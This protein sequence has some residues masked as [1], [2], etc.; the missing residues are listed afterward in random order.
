MILVGPNNHTIEVDDEPS[1]RRLTG[2]KGYKEATK[3]QIEAYRLR[4][5]ESIERAKHEPSPGGV[6]YQTVQSSPDGYGMSRDI[7]KNELRKLGVEM[8]EDFRDQKVGLLYSYP[9]GITG[10]KTDVRLI[11]TMFESDEIPQDW[12]EYLMAAD[13]VLVPSKWCSDVFKKSGINTTIVP[14]GYN[15]RVFNY[16]H[17][18][19]PVEKS[20]PFTF[21]HYDSFN[22]RKGF[23]EVLEAFSQE[24]KKNEP[25]K[26]IL[27]TVRPETPVP[28]VPSQYPNVE[29]V[30][31]VLDEPELL[32]LLSKSH[33]MV[34]PSRG[35]GFGIT[36]LEAMATG[37]P[38]IVPNAHGITE[39]FNAQYM[40]EVNVKE[41]IP[42]LY[43]KFKNQPTG[44]MVLCDI[45]HLKKQMRYAFNHQEEMRE[46][47]R[48]A[49]DY[50]KRFTYQRTAENLKSVIERWQHKE[51]VKRPE[52]NF[53][54]VEAVLS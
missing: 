7:V 31:G 26:L 43:K 14:L 44:E 1:I 16:I 53:L 2:E 6:Y 22:I 42:G 21:I 52:S 27:K 19:I 41:K 39:Y 38:A 13:E 54:K 25:V 18:D 37:I 50:V 45:D 49:S 32:E 9:Y 46:L 48:Q 51:V 30:K 24:F 15:D 36:P 35:E 3:E 11:Y 4:V 23:F 28:I 5:Q 40:L 12:P 20:Q 8:Q 17:R 10:I 34:Y 47:G 29:V 33:C